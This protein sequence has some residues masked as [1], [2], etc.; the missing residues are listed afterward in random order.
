MW[1]C[2]GNHPGAIVAVVLVVVIAIFIVAAVVKFHT[3]RRSPE[4]IKQIDLGAMTEKNKSKNAA[5]GVGESI[6]SV[7]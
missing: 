6:K 5:I 1:V 3:T 7:I 2:I 4:V